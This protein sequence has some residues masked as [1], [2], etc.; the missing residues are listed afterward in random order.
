[1]YR[2]ILN[3]KF[4]DIIFYAIIFFYAILIVKDANFG[5]I[6]DHGLLDTILIGKKL[7]L[8]IIPEIGR[9]F[10]LNGFE[11]SIISKISLSPVAFYTYNALQLLIL[12]IILYRIL[13]S[14]LEKNETSEK[15][16]KYITYLVIFLLML[17]PGFVTA[18]FRL[19]V[20]ERDVL[21]FLIIFIY[22]YLLYQGNQIAIYLLSGLI[23]ANIALYYKEP[24][25]LMI[26]SLAFFHLLFGWKKLNIKQKIFDFLLILSSIVFISIY[27]FV[28]Y[29]NK[30]DTL[31]GTI[32]VPAL[33]QL[34]KIS[35]NYAS[36]DPVIIFILLPL[37]LWRIYS[38]FISKKLNNIYDPILFSALIYILVFFKLNMFSYHYLLPAYSFG[39]I[40]I[41]Y[42][43]FQ[44]QLY[45]KIT[46]KVLLIL[47]S[48]FILFSSIPT[49]LHLISH[50]KNVPNNFQAV[51]D[52]LS[53]Y[54]KEYSREGKRVSIFI[55][56]V[57]R[58]EGVEIYH[59]FIKYLEFKGVNCNQF[60]IKSDE[61]DS[62]ILPLKERELE[63]CYTIWK[64]KTASKIQSGDL[65]ILTPYT[66][67]YIEL[68]KKAIKNLEQEY[69]LLYQTKSTF[70]EIPHLGIKS[71]IKAY[72]TGKIKV[73]K[74]IISNNIYGLPLDFYVFRKK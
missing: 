19:F 52:F 39:L 10:P 37:G 45:K 72:A 28:V 55:D 16:R 65:I 56:G 49:G 32:N 69:E 27:Y 23:S 12:I 47:T 53:T 18:W 2:N 62:G 58:N 25:F 48:F 73:N 6:D 66:K 44:E 46:F 68:N 1:M 59:S 51:L 74:M 34:I 13:M 21:F 22:F 63:N 57:N 29:L 70:I 33:I 31:Y 54:I 43:I 30:E 7:P 41:T 60:D 14:I 9:F 42:F 11:L 40:G 36:S 35:V 5:V 20:P 61:D 50:Y 67:R 17:T 71:I 15:K 64:Q 24:V 8:F 26:G 3:S 4:F 38:I